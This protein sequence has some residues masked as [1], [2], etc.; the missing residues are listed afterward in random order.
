MCRELVS[1]QKL[2]AHDG[3]MVMSPVGSDK[4]GN[5]TLYYPDV[6]KTD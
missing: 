4:M 6:L 2:F 1:A 5:Q 3:E